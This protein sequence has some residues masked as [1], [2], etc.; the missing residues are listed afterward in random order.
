M[1]MNH[2][3]LRFKH[4]LFHE[5]HGIKEVLQKTKIIHMI[6]RE[7]KKNNATRTNCQ[8]SFCYDFSSVKNKSACSAR[9]RGYRVMKSSFSG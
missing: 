7:F 1:I 2:G 3:T 8:K 5:K 9:G 6:T 4:H